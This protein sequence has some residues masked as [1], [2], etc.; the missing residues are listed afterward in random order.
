MEIGVQDLPFT[1]GENT[2]WAFLNKIQI[3]FLAWFSLTWWVLRNQIK[4]ECLMGVFALI[5]FA[6]HFRNFELCI[7]TVSIRESFSKKG[8]GSCTR[9][10]KDSVSRGRKKLEMTWVMTCFVRTFLFG[11]IFRVW[12]IGEFPWGQA[13]FSWAIAFALEPLIQGVHFFLDWKTD[14]ECFCKC[15]KFFHKL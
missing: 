14:V 10:S 7:G 2:F 6:F 11:D 5:D 9:H 15:R 13:A 1:G 12:E 3:I 8:C 4:G